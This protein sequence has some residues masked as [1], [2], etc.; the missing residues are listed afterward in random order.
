MSGRYLGERFDIHGGG[1]DLIF[2]HHE[3]EIAQSRAVFGAGSFAHHWMHNGFI[4][5]RTSDDVEEKMSKSLGNFF[6]IK[7]VLARHEPEALRLFLLG[8]HYRKPITFEVEPAEEGGARYISLEDAEKRLAYTYTTLARLDQALATGKEPGPGEVLAPA[9]DFTERFDAALDD[10][11]NTAAAVGFS[12]ELL[13]LANKL[14]DQPKAAPKPVRR[15]TLTAIRAGLRHVHRGLGVFG[16][17]PQLF[18]ERR[19]DKLCVDREIDPQQVGELILRRT[20]ARKAKDFAGADALRD[21]LVSK[22]VELMDS[23]TGTSWRVTED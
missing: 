1:M 23:P 7:D 17:D 12:S 21:E 16:Q 18:L 13:T 6:T 11:F 4:N 20:E 22:G 8:T 14:L 19:R 3:N 9:D 2:P 15:R 10:D 5:V